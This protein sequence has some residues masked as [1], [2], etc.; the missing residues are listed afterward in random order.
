MAYTIALVGNPNAGKTTLFNELTGSTAHVG[1]WPGVTVEKKEGRLR[2][3]NEA[4]LVDLPGVYSLSPYS[5]EEVLARDFLIHEAPDVI[6]N[7]IDASN[8]ERNLYLTTQILEMG[9]PTVIAA[10]MIDLVKRNGDAFDSSRLAGEL[11]VP[12]IEISALQ[13][14]G[15]DELVA[16]VQSAVKEK[17]KPI[18][19]LNYGEQVEV[20]L[21]DIQ[22]YVKKK[23]MATDYT[24]INDR[25]LAVK[26]FEQDEKV[27]KAAPL[28]AELEEDI[29]H[30]EDELGEEAE[31]LIP[32]KRYQFIDYLSE[33]VYRKE[34]ADEQT[35]SEK[36]D[37]VVTNRWLGL[38]I[39]VGIIF[40]VYY[41]SIQ[42]V[43][44]YA[45]DF[46]NDVVI[47]EWA[48]GGMM[49]LLTSLGASPWLIA[50]VVD[51]IIAG[52]GA[53][54]GFL[55]QMAVLFILLTILEQC[56]YM[57][58]I[59]FVLDRVFSSFGLSGKSFIP[60]LVGTGCSVPGIMAARTIENEADRRLT[61]ITTSFMPCSAK[62]PIIAFI[63]GAIFEDAWW[64]APIAYFLGIAAVIFSGI[65]LKKTKSF[66]S[67]PTPFVME[68]P[69][70]RL[71][72]FKG[73]VRTVGDKLISFVQKAGTVILVSSIILWFLQAFG[74]T[75][76][77]IGLV[78]DAIDQSFLAKLG[79]LVAWIFTPLGFGDWQ[80]T[81][82]TITG[83][84]AKE[85]I[86]STFAILFNVSGDALELIETSDWSA[87]TSI[88]AHYT[89]IA[90][91]SFLSFNLLCQPCFAAVGAMHRELGDVRWTLFGV[92]YQTVIA[93]SFA[94]IFYQFASFFTT[95]AFTFWTV[96]A[97]V[98]FLFWMFMVFR[99][100]PK[101]AYS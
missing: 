81:V 50:L 24:D 78:G 51:G 75:E 34:N 15:L 89:P 8:L 17:K 40:I 4:T 61:A 73:I 36:I 13:G 25:W 6:I 49:N 30:L 52:V 100:R 10:N 94:L 58:R 85:N 84:I 41:L 96:V 39:F 18:F 91:F 53:V 44:T 68:L 70:Y 29:R 60:M 59:A 42:T 66:S 19:R 88:T 35:L 74:R 12:V 33:L 83:L 5:L 99:P 56:G 72:T 76:D 3:D 2:A 16:K 20:I 64:F 21:S 90:A 80:S 55:P 14:K 87:L 47:A 71:P 65:V 63:A 28:C 92:M 54:L 79:N 86:M 27:M 43:G 7:I 62:L 23:G 97:L 82:A 69:E 98:V 77:G 48:Q 45:T 37:R 9:I 67:D 26:L 101:S 95:G 57:A 38:P 93:Y 32:Q 11:G 46:V 31:S 22:L 1:N